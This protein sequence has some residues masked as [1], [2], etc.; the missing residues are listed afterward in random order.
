MFTSD[1]TRKRLANLS[2]SINEEL[3]KYIVKKFYKLDISN[4][5]TLGAVSRTLD[6]SPYV[7]VVRTGNI[8]TNI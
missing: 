7:V 5:P 8:L 1:N 2:S 6:I 3:E 4:K